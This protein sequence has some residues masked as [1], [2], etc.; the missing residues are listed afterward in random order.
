MSKFVI[1]GGKSLEG[2]VRVHGMKNA[3]TPILVATLLTQE[4]CIINNVPQISDVRK[5]VEILQSLGAKVKWLDEH[6]LSTVS[7]THLTLP[8]KRIV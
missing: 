1:Q 8:T 5:M 2:E 3:A 7:Y 4:E 6:S